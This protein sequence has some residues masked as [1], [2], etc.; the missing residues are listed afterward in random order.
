MGHVLP[1]LQLFRGSLALHSR[2]NPET[3]HA[4]TH[5]HTTCINPPT[6]E[7]R[8]LSYTVRPGALLSDLTLRFLF[9]WRRPLLC[10]GFGRLR[11][12]QS[13]LD[14]RPEEDPAIKL[15]PLNLPAF[16]G[17]Q[18]GQSQSRAV[19]F[20][21]SEKEVKWIDGFYRTRAILFGY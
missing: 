20:K 12:L 17:S 13:H 11:H 5:A 16:T 15:I 10:G 1:T 9:Y 4:D 21:L 19:E 3:E 8:A 14:V 18:A 7:P 6:R 2:L